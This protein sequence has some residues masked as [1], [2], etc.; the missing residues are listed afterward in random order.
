MI[1]NK[2]FINMQSFVGKIKQV[3]HH[4]YFRADC[5]SV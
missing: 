3:F 1:K 4:M 5:L 2:C